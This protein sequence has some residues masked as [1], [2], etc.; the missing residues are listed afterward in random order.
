MKKVYICIII[1]ILSSLIYFNTNKNYIKY[2]LTHLDYENKIS[3][4]DNKYIIK[5]YFPITNYTKLD[6]E[7]NKEINKYITDFTSNINN[8]SYQNDI[9]YTLYI[10]YDRYD[11][12][13]YISV[14]FYIESFLGGAHPNHIIKTIVFDKNR[15]K[16]ITIDDLIKQNKNIL[17]KLSNISRK[18]LNKNGKYNSSKYSYDLFIEGTK[19]IKNNF[20][21]FTFT[22]NGLKIYFNYYQ[23][24]PYYFGEASIVIPYNDLNLKY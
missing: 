4:V 16:I 20:N 24:A 7:I 8:Y 1:I 12:Q 19:P 15:N 22:N 18:E 17:D 21:N 11:Y 9:Y 2:A 6:K 23:I 14:A 3:T 13:N 10:N 5:I